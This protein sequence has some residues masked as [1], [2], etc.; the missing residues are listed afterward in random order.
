[1]HGFCVGACG[2]WEYVIAGEPIEQIKCTEP[3]AVKGQVVIS[4]QVLSLVA[5]LVLTLPIISDDG[6]GDAV[7]VYLLCAVYLRSEEFVGELVCHSLFR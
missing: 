1:M 3:V 5:D 7:E 6:G 2:R 4:A